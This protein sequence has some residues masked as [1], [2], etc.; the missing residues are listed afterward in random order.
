M[1]TRVHPILVVALIALVFAGS[2]VGQEA[3]SPDALQAEIQDTNRRLEQVRASAAAVDQVLAIGLASDEVGDLLHESR[4][5]LPLQQ[6]LLSR[7][8]ARERMVAE[9]KLDLVRMLDQHRLAEPADKPGLRESILA[10][11]AYV[12]VAEE[13]L[14][15][16]QQLAAEAS[17]LASRLDEELLWIRSAEPIGVQWVNDVGAGIAWLAAPGQW[18]LVA[19]TALRGAASHPVLSGLGVVGILGLLV[20]RRRFT[21]REAQL[22]ELTRRLSTDTFSLTLR[23]FLFTVLRVL[24]GPAALLGVCALLLGAGE[25][26]P[27][28]IAWGS[29]AASVVWFALGFSRALCRVG[30]L[31]V[32]H[33]SWDARSCRVLARHLRWLI[34]IQA[35]AAFIDACTRATGDELYASGLGRLAFL[36]ATLALVAFAA[37]V[38]RPSHGVLSPFL[39]KD[40]WAWRLRRVWYT[41]L[42]AIPLGLAVAAAVGY[43]YTAT[44]IQTRLFLSGLIVLLGVAAYSLLARWV[45]I[46]RR[47]VALK[48]ARERLAEEREARERNEDADAP[49]SGE[50][51]PELDPQVLDVDAASEQTRTLLRIGAIA[52][53]AALLW[54]VWADVLP[55]LAVLERVELAGATLDAESAVI[56]PAVTLWSLTLVALVIAATVVAARNLPAVLELV[57]LARFPIDAGTRYAI[58]TLVRYVVIAGGVFWAS[59]LIGIEWGR[60]Q[61]IIAALGVGLGFGLQEIVANFVSGLIILF[62]RPVRV[63]D[64]VTVGE[65]SGTVSRLQIRATTI[66][67]WDNK[68][69]LVPNKA[70]ITDRVINWTLS[71]SVTR[72]LIPVG[73]AYGSDVVKAHDAIVN[74]VRSVPA[75]LDDP[76][77]SVLLIGFGDSSLDFEVRA[78]VGQ[79]AQRLPT[80]HALHA[81]IESSLREA[82]IEIPFPQRDLWLRAKDASEPATDAL[83]GRP[84]EA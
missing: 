48:Q 28:A 82:G 54:A 5:R 64:V 79:L 58:V 73:V 72:L 45:S 60:V 21:R 83:G 56:V 80:T 26:F 14:E 15:A 66:T 13:A 6:D 84:N 23:A 12:A 42:V 78:F 27:I 76:A 37:L 10:Q 35:A 62:E 49:V 4:S 32:A 47:R 39:S 40:G 22:A 77:P 52:G 3:P 69:I 63:G 50:A 75:V 18:R 2:G 71:S 9:A 74:A 29:L 36:L 24:P 59:H 25:G 51:T 55:A 61:W 70:F 53:I 38:F 33:L 46:A 8:A 16:E 17:A 7:V 20:G 41:P 68:E 34:P 1:I 57:V 81:A 43:Y 65:V 44:V 30:G 19:Q 11:E 67:D 31:A